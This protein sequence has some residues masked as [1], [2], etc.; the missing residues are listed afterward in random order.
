MIE[1]ENCKCECV[2]I[3]RSIGYNILVNS[4]VCQPVNTCA[5]T[6]NYL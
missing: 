5:P 2:K 3:G 4:S 6:R 1:I